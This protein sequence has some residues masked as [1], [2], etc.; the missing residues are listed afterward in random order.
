MIRLESQRGQG[1]PEDRQ[2]KSEHPLWMEKLQTMLDDLH[3]LRKGLPR[4]VVFIMCDED[5]WGS[6]SAGITTNEEEGGRGGR[7]LAD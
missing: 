7:E 6:E 5:A 4:F 3:T 1:C 2:Y